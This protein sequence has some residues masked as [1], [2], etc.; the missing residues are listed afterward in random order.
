MSRKSEL[1][2]TRGPFLR[3]IL[4][5]SVP[6]MFTGLLQL[7][8]N[9]AD[10]A[11]VTYGRISAE[12]VKACDALALQGKKVQMV[13]L[14]QIHPLPD[15]ALDLLREKRQIFFFEEGLRTGGAGEQTALRLLETGFRGR[16]RL[17]A[18]PDC[19]VAQA[20]VKEQLHK[21]GLNSDSMI[22]TILNITETEA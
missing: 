7:A 11:I 8:Y 18:V 9:T 5:F 2:M 10:T 14:N 20:S 12:A 19:F 1:D 22:Q 3:K 17:T 6:L 16:F 4:I 15:G 13:A 21:Y